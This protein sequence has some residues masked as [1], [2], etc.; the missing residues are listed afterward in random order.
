MACLKRELSPCA[1]DPR[2][3]LVAYT[4][5]VHTS[6]LPDSGTEANAYVEL[7]SL[8]GKT[9]KARVL[10]PRTRLPAV[11]L[12]SPSCSLATVH[13]PGSER[14]FFYCV[15]QKA[16]LWTRTASGSSGITAPECLQITCRSRLRLPVG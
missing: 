5:D 2:Q 14:G 16:A 11:M 6:R 7:V 9:G 13:V 8:K 12:T 3:E 1:T 15:H 10:R 4:V